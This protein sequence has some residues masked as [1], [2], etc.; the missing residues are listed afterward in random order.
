MT[1]NRRKFGVMAGFFFVLRPLSGA[2]SIE[3]QPLGH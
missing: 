1:F 3:T 2:E